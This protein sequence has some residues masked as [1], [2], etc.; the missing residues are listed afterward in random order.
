MKICPKCGIENLDDSRYCFFC[1]FDF[2]ANEGIKP[3]QSANAPVNPPKTNLKKLK[4]VRNSNSQTAEVPVQNQNKNQTQ[5]TYD[6]YYPYPPY[7]N[8]PPPAEP[9]ANEN[10]YGT[11]DEAAEEKP[12]TTPVLIAIIAL[13]ICAL[14]ILGYMFLIQKKMNENVE[15]NRNQQNSSAS[16]SVQTIPATET[17]TSTS[18]TLTT[19]V[20]SSKT[21]A[22][23]TTVV[24]SS[25]SRKTTVSA[26]IVTTVVS[27]RKI[28]ATTIVSSV[29]N[30]VTTVVSSR[31]SNAKATTVVSSKQ[32][33]VTTTVAPVAATVTPCNL[34]GR[35]NTHGGVVASF[36][37]SYVVYGGSAEKVRSS[38]G[39]DWNIKAS[40]S[41]YSMGI[42]W[43]EV[44]D[45]DDGDYYG[46]VDSE[47]VDFVSPRESQPSV[48]VNSCNIRGAIRTYGEIV[49]GYASSY[50]VDGGNVATV[51]GSLGDWDVI[52]VNTCYSMGITWYELYD[53]DDGDYYGWVD[54]GYI[55]FDV[56]HITPPQSKSVTVTPCNLS[57][58]INTYGG[59]VAGFSSTYVVD[60]GSA[61]LVRAS[62]GDWNVTA[63]NTCYSM[64]ITWYELYDADDGDYYG[65]VDA[66][67]ISF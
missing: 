60:G 66:S 62:L 13:L 41:C 64:G 8:A 18:T 47:Y 23:T 20:S 28:A 15:N 22:L 40:N 52:A 56:S 5:T 6:P 17:E 21:T 38:L 11:D 10:F 48:T 45:A 24:S 63:V 55:N 42:T 58:K 33:V 65:W 54:S 51:R 67:Y 50:V 61:I 32:A 2:Y 39:N 44:Y 16:V 14:C 53:A 43:Y 19:T 1:D 36:A 59:T 26:E 30:S 31:K 29:R 12:R 27:S 9:P 25:S 35:I 49:S 4:P 34:V 7:N 57:G 3:A 37:S 46:W